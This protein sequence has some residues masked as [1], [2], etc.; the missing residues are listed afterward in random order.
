MAQRTPTNIVF[1]DRN[2]IPAHIVLP[3]P[4]SPHHWQA[5]GETQPDEVVSRLQEAEVA[6]TNKVVIDE[7]VLAACP[8]LKLIAVAATG[9]NNVDL[10]ACRA[11]GVQVCNVQGYATQ[12]VP[13]HVIALIFALKRQ[14]LGY[15][16]DVQHGAWQKHGQ[17]C[18]FTHP[19]G[20]VAG[21]QLGI[22]GKGVLGEAVAR[23]ARAVGMTVMF[24]E[25]R[26]A[27]HCR[28]GYVPFDEVIS[29]ADIL[30]LH[31]P[32]N[33]NTEA[34]INRD[35]LACMPNHALL[36][37]TGRGGLVD[38]HAL[39][40][41]LKT[42]QIGGAGLDVLSEEPAPDD[43]PLITASLPN[44]IVTPHIA[45]GADEAVNRLSQQLMDNIDGY[46]QGTPQ[47]TLINMAAR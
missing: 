12:S 42:G 26:G 10:A 14:L 2:T 5:Y 7:T 22:I 46:L 35:V 1:L 24:A 30:S 41:A 34:L 43:H 16:L 32:L 8:Q 37:N 28:E 40:D 18:F 21:S 36:I 17:F 27:T 38:E 3:T 44:L 23:L 11:R 47:H 20:S 19:I 39:L 25:H 13:E 6:I 33:P 4:R 45:W 9:V 15:H 29:R 31:C